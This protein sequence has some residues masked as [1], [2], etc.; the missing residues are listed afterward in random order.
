MGASARQIVKDFG[1]LVIKAKNAG[2]R[3]D[4]ELLP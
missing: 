2:H 3:G 1:S 4:I